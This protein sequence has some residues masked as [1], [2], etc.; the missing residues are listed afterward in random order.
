MDA[1]LPETKLMS[2]L[3]EL[4]P[5]LEIENSSRNDLILILYCRSY[6]NNQQ[7]IFSLPYP[8][9]RDINHVTNSEDPTVTA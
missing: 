8:Q 1:L 7:M 3:P 2:S 9:Y 4:S 5:S 6:F